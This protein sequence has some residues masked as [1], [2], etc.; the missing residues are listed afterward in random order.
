MRVFSLVALL[1]AGLTLAAC[2]PT[3]G[4]TQAQR[5]PI[6]A[7]EIEEARI[8]GSALTAVERLRPIWLSRA[9][10]APVYI[11]DSRAGSTPA[12]LGT[13]GIQN[14]V[15]IERMNAGEATTRFGGGHPQGAFL[16]Y[17][18]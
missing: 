16:V 6:T 14:V 12:T 7:S 9:A 10:Q 13:I 11:D 8:T 5:G 3:E 4:A 2:A 1:A 18:H 15:R 17:T